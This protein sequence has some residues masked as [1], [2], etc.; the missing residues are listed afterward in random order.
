MR[1]KMLSIPKTFVILYKDKICS[2]IKRLLKVEI[3]DMH[4]AP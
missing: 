4:E 3:E 1:E 2:Q